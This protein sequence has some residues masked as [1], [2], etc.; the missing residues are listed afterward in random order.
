[1]LVKGDDTRI[2]TGPIEVVSDALKTSGTNEIVN[3]LSCLAC[4]QQGMKEFTDQIRTGAAVT[5]EAALKVRR[6]YPEQKRMNELLAADRARYL[7]ALAQAVGPFLDAG[8]DEQSAEPQAEPIGFVAR[9]YALTPLN[10]AAA[11]AELG[12]GDSA[13]LQS[14]LGE[15]R[16]RELGLLPL[17]QGDSLSRHDWETGQGMSLMQRVSRE[18]GYTPFDVGLG[19]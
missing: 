19:E 16:M 4:H 13:Q 1:M 8:E 15:N 6:L 12:L 11:A 14:K 9:L 5:G 3:G 18:L 2:D 7:A 10:L 17:V